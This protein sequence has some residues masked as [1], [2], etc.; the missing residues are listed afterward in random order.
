MP[1]DA[2]QAEPS[3]ERER[4]IPVFARTK[5]L[6]FFLTIS[7]AINLMLGLGVFAAAGFL[8]LKFI[9]P[10]F[11]VIS[12][13]FIATQD[14]GYL[15]AHHVEFFRPRVDF[16]NAFLRMVT[17]GLLNGEP[18]GY[19][20]SFLEPYVSPAVLRDYA[21][22]MED[23]TAR[24]ARFNQ[25][26]IW[27]MQEARRYYEKGFSKYMVIAIKGNIITYEDEELKGIKGVDV[28]VKPILI[29]IHLLAAPYSRTN[30]WG[31][32]VAAVREENNESR[33]QKIWENSRDLAK[34]RD[35][36]GQPILPVPAKQ[37]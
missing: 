14:Y 8:F 10:P 15:T 35:V 2:T 32:Y 6:S 12:P 36:R 34:T 1:S 19:N 28:N 4:P 13:P 22:I 5:R 25:R 27:N 30:P 17:E 9:S 24:A 31:L 3:F 21:Q 18:L 20:A 33:I 26:K 23:R 29:L 7:L 16:I 37:N 11:G